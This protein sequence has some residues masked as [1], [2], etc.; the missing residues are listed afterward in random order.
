MLSSD[1]IQDINLLDFT[2]TKLLFHDNTIRNLPNLRIS[3][4]QLYLNPRVMMDRREKLTE[5]ILALYKLVYQIIQFSEGSLCVCGSSITRI[6]CSGIRVKEFNLYFRSCTVEKAN[7]ILQTIITIPNILITYYTNSILIRGDECY[8]R[9]HLDIYSSR[10]NILKHNGPI[11]ERHGWDPEIGYFAFPSA[12][13]LF[14]SGFF[15]DYEPDNVYNSLPRVG[16]LGE[17]MIVDNNIEVKEVQEFPGIAFH[18]VNYDLCDIKVQKSLYRLRKERIF[19]V[20]VNKDINCNYSKGWYYTPFYPIIIE[21]RLFAPLPKKKINFKFI[22]G[23]D[24]SS[25]IIG[26]SND[27]YVAFA[28]CRIKYN[29]TY[30]VFRLLCR[31]WLIMEYLC[32]R[33]RLIK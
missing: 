5:I 8:I 1:Y 16:N 26:I 30:D 7:S 15:P 18:D 32:V 23:E 29:I 4:H 20:N 6:I 13:F 14:A 17:P 11:T 24:Y 33:E 3:Y 19:C 22:L 2:E 27:R 10:V 28:L 9:V 21:T 12:A 31:Q 25:S